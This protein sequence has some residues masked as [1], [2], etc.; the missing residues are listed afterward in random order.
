MV[1]RGCSPNWAALIMISRPNRCFHIAFTR[2]DFAVAGM[3]ETWPILR[4]AKHS[5]RYL[6]SGKKHFDANFST[7]EDV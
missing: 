7:F 1:S 5:E 2:S 4:L 3:P 6:C